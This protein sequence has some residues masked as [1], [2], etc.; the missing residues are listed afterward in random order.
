MVSFQETGIAALHKCRM[1]VI[2]T[3]V[4][5]LHKVMFSIKTDWLIKEYARNEARYLPRTR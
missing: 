4:N 2:H 3:L 5:V 1:I